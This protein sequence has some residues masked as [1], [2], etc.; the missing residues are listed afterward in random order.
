MIIF[1][2][3]SLLPGHEEQE[4]GDSSHDDTWRP[5]PEFELDF[6]DTWR[7]E[8]ELGSVLGRSGRGY[9]RGSSNTAHRSFLIEE[10]YSFLH[11]IWTL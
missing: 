7:I 9:S 2:N 3:F 11:N 10:L 8:Q 5:E 6:Y 4:L 1:A